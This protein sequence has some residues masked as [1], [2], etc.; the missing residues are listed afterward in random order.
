MSTS[1]PAAWP[2]IAATTAITLPSGYVIQLRQELDTEAYYTLNDI[3]LEIAQ[4]G[5][6]EARPDEI[7]ADW[8]PTPGQ[9]VYR[10]R[11]FT[12]E[13]RAHLRELNRDVVLL[14][15][16]AWDIRPPFAPESA[17]PMPVTRDALKNLRR[18]I[19]QE[20]DD[21]V[22]R[23]QQPLLDEIAGLFKAG[24]RG[25]EEAA[26]STPGAMSS[27]GSASARTRRRTP[28]P[29]GPSAGSPAR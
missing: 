16:D 5:W 11:E 17:P 23:H 9:P 3:L 27:S 13:H 19:T 14:W 15:L 28:S 18:E 8:T 10:V 26:P 22:G 21:A 29:G 1:R 7:P 6:R 4:M 20:I 2:D 25:N 24:P 12:R